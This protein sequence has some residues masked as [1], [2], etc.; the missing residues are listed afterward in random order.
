MHIKYGDYKEIAEQ[1]RKMKL[2]GSAVIIQDNAEWVTVLPEDEYDIGGELA[3]ILIE[4]SKSFN[5]IGVGYH[6]F[7]DDYMMLIITKCGEIVDRYYSQAGRLDDEYYGE[8]G[9]GWKGRPDTAASAIG[10]DAEE[11]ALIYRLTDWKPFDKNR[12]F[13]KNSYLLPCVA[14]DRIG[15]M[16]NFHHA[17]ESF[18]RFPRQ[19]PYFEHEYD[20]IIF[21]PGNYLPQWYPVWSNAIYAVFAHRPDLLIAL[22]ED[23]VNEKSI[24]MDFPPL[25]IAVALGYEDIVKIL[26][27]K[28]NPINFTARYGAISCFHIVAVSGNESMAKMLIESGAR[29]NMKNAEGKTP[30]DYAKT[31]RMKSLIRKHGGKTGKEVKT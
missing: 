8:K 11:L 14:A 29:I 25:F 12:V 27:E 6:N 15:N 13:D 1:I 28:G 22:S 31:E 2:N 24:Y 21:I 18:S 30:L 23:E 16:L 10:I 17:H 3:A 5:T 26:I 4:L 19:I 7:D 9:R 20:K